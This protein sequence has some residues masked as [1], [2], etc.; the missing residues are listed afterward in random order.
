MIISEL[1]NKK[2]AILGLGIEN[3]ALV[4]YLLKI[5]VRRN[6]ETHRDASLR[7]DI[8]VCNARSREEL[9]KKYRELSKYKNIKWRLGKNYDKGVYE[10]DILFRSPGWPIY[11]IRNSK[12]EIRNYILSSPMKL[13]FKL[14]P[15][16]NIVGVT[17][18]KG[19]GTTASLIYEILKKAGKRVWLGG[20]IGIAPFEFLNKIKRSDWVILEL[21]SFQLEDM[22]V[23]PRIA[24][25]TNFY[26]E[27]LAPADPNNPNFHKN[28]RAYQKAKSN[29]FRHQKRGDKLVISYQLSVM[30]D[31]KNAQVKKIIFAKS[32]LPSRLIGEHNKEN[33]AAA[34]AVAKIV[35][36]KD[37][38]IK[39]AVAQ[40]KGLEHRLEFVR[41]I[42]TPPVKGRRGVKKIKPSF[43]KG[44]LRHSFGEARGVGGFISFYNDS[45]ATTPESAIIALKSFPGPVILLVGGA[46]KNS[47]FRPL[48]REIKRRVYPVK[49]KSSKAG[50]MPQAR[51]FNRVK[52]VV[53][54]DGKATGRIN[55]ELLKIKYPKDKI[56]LA[57]SMREAV[58]IVRNVAKAGDTVL[59]SPACASFGMF[60]NYKERGKLFKLEVRKL[61]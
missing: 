51:Q 61:K 40:F 31:I 23:S 58:R 9:G 15:T 45:F 5:G 47:D 25:I 17:G 18:T 1:K 60:K 34:A 11:K 7:Y 41:T 37:N 10:F 28:L 4:R 6:V 8:T 22:E 44:P 3:Y 43:V 13:F 24:V 42:K 53:L 27:H 55:K 21:S 32:K 14:C 56:K 57:H 2:I 50:A 19:K 36:I 52:F 35:G 29:I 48:A 49:V 30:E 59:L 20:N 33:I 54:L 12:F 46:E 26:S 39:K 16:K 38:V